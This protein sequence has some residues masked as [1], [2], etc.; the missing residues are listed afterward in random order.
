MHDIAKEAQKRYNY[1][2]QK[3][4]NPINDRDLKSRRALWFAFEN[5]ALVY[6]PQ[7]NAWVPPSRCIWAKSHVNIPGKASI[8]EVYPLLNTFFTNILKVAEPSIEMYIEALK[9]EV[10]G[11]AS[12]VNI[13]DIMKSISSSNLEDA[14]LSSLR[15]AKILPVK[16][17]DGTHSLVSPRDGSLD[18]AVVETDAHWDAFKGKIAAL[19]FS[20]EEVRDTR[21]LLL[22]IGL[23]PRFSTQ[24]VREVTIAGDNFQQDHDMTRNLQD[25]D[26]ALIWYVISYHQS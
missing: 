19:D 17:A 13:I 25:K 11:N 10:Q 9:F 26:I 18:F 23:R 7:E 20:I 6:I 8:A 22:A 12:V 16:L 3:Q 24:L 15:T 5:S 14:D 4:S 1:L 21:P 2:Y